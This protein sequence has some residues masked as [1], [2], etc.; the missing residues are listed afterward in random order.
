MSMP[1][2][3]DW[4]NEWKINSKTNGSWTKT[5]RSVFVTSCVEG[6]GCALLETP[7]LDP[8]R[9]PKLRRSAVYWSIPVHV[10]RRDWRRLSTFLDWDSVVAACRRR[11]VRVWRS[12]STNE[13]CPDRCSV[14]HILVFWQSPNYHR[15]SCRDTTVCLRSDRRNLCSPHRSRWL[16]RPLGA[17][18]PNVP[19]DADEDWS[20]SH[21]L[22][23]MRSL[24]MLVEF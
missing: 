20:E 15:F 5:K 22:E 13:Q 17:M 6:T 23:A 12:C 4:W 8:C 7:S 9:Y 14:L 1:R 24:I 19:V 21:S 18:C 16:H 11:P 3:A 2:I 10:L